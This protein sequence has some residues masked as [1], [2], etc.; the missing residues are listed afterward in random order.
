MPRKQDDADDRPRRRR[1]VNDDDDDRPS[2]HRKPKRD[3]DDDDRPAVRRKPRRDEEEDDDRP[4][5][6]RRRNLDDDDRP[7]RKRRKKKATALTANTAGL[8]AIGLTIFAVLMRFTCFGP[9]GI[10]PAGAG[11]YLAAN[12]FAMAQK[13]NSR[14]SPILP[15]IGVAACLLAAVLAIGSGVRAA[16]EFQA[17]YEDRMSRYDD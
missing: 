14:Q 9:F 11:L 8:I 7:R 16:R 13:S 5:I 4:A 3:E 2:A 1:P 10:I 15:A 12:A 6:K 17:G